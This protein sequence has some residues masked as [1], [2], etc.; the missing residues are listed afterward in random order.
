MKSKKPF[1]LKERVIDYADMVMSITERLPTTREGDSIR[2][3]LADAAG[4]VGANVHEADGALTKR[5]TRKSFGIAHKELHE[6]RFW[7]RLV[8]RKWGRKIPVPDA[9]QE[10]L[11]LL[12]IVGTIIPEAEREGLWVRTLRGAA[13]S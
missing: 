10:T 1:D 9:L 3:Q 7:L 12:S 4:S 6:C 11:E 13:K 8:D 2:G 5:D